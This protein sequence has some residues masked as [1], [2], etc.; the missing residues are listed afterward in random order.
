MNETQIEPAALSKDPD[1]GTIYLWLFQKVHSNITEVPW[2]PHQRAEEEAGQ[3]GGCLPLAFSL[4]P[5][6]SALKQEIL[7]R[8]PGAGK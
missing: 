3:V 1:L 5:P 8:N 6:P 4:P 2:C 7:I